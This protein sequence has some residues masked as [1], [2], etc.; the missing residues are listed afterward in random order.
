MA[1]L[2]NCGTPIPIYPEKIKIDT[3]ALEGFEKPQY[4]TAL[5]FY[6]QAFKICEEMK[7]QQSIVLKG[8]IKTYI[9]AE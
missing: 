2:I 9:M 7:S 1:E 6:E 8:L 3:K 4:K 5:I